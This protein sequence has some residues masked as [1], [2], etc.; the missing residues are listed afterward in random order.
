M[1]RQAMA[2]LVLWLALTAHA[3]G[4][5]SNLELPVADYAAQLPADEPAR[6]LRIARSTWFNRPGAAVIDPDDPISRA[7]W[8]DR[9][10]KEG[11]PVRESDAIV[12]GMVETG[13]AFVSEDRR[14]LY[15][16]FR[17][18]VETVI[19]DVNTTNKMG[20][21][22]PGDLIAMLRR[23]GALRL[24]SGEIVKEVWR[25][26]GLPRVASRYVLFLTRVP[27]IEGFQILTGYRIKETE[28]APLDDGWE[29][30]AYDGMALDEFLA[31]IQQ[32][33]G[34]VGSN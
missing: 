10:R 21:L 6:S 20:A 4:T 16:E 33:V 13:E 15:A 26:H 34:H 31:R 1:S 18:R 32:V 12:I 24:P 8:S 22:Q 9:V 2:S 28:I 30:P 11:P 3:Q 27:E 29:Y 5:L 7:I 25:T 14:A 19:K 23:G 17:V